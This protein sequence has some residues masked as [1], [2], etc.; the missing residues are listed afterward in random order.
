M[1]NPGYHSQFLPMIHL[2]SQV[3]F[4]LNG[5]LAHTIHMRYRMQYIVRMSMWKIMRNS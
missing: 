1:L 3:Q 5:V 2:A 4:L